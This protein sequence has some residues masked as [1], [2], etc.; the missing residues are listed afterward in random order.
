[1]LLAINLTRPSVDF[2]VYLSSFQRSFGTTC[3]PYGG[4]CGVLRHDSPKVGTPS[5][6]ASTC[7]PRMSPTTGVGLAKIGLVEAKKIKQQAGSLA[8]FKVIS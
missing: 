2:L 8:W 1:M 6:R 3:A 4:L 7:F 5:G